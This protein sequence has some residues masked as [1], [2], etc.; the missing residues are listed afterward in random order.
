MIFVIPEES[1]PEA[2]RRISSL[3]ALYS[4][5]PPEFP[6]SPPMQKERIVMLKKSSRIQ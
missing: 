3:F 5:Q 2:R 1:L 4:A 6:G